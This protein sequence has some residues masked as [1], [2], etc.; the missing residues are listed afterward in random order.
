MT[1][2]AKEIAEMIGVSQATLSLVINNR[3]GISE[4]T[5]SRVIAELKQ[6]GFDYLLSPET[7]S[8]PVESPAPVIER[9]LGFVTYRIGGEL[10]GFNS[11]FPLIVQGIENAASREQ[12][13]VTYLNIDRERADDGIRQLRSS[14]CA[15]YVIFAT[16]LKEIDL[17]PFEKLGVPF[18]I[19][20]NYFVS[21]AINT[22][23]VNNE[24]G[25]Y[26]AVEHLV[27]MGHRKIGYLR[28]GVDINSFEERFHRAMDAMYRLGCENPEKYVYEIGY[29]SD[30]AAEGM[31]KLLD[32]KVELP[33]AFIGDNDLVVAGAMRAVQMAGYSVPNDMSFVGFDDR[34]VC[35]WMVPALTSVRLPRE[36]FGGEAVNLLLRMLE[37]ESD[38][39]LKIE[40]N[41]DLVVR[42]SVLK[43]EVSPEL[44]ERSSVARNKAE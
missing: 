23:K 30:H 32:E 34:P 43:V 26:A 31:K 7:V 15:G 44:I 2:K 35:E 18:V 12:Y 11:F 29:P 6:R 40:I 10:L 27:G 1:L 37:G 38:I 22:V 9:R 13:S 14:G 16:E 5:R 28:S 17:T 3:P 4:K 25:T 41:P 20:D 39:A 19:L 21:H 24:R 36:R 33:T 42:Q 8:A